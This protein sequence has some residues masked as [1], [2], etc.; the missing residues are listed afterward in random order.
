M[1]LKVRSVVPVN[2][3][4]QIKAVSGE[5]RG[6]DLLRAD[7]SEEDDV[8]SDGAD[9]DA[10]YTRVIRHDRGLSVLDDGSLHVVT[11]CRLN[12][13]GGGRDHLSY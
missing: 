5:A 12:L 6:S 4:N 7:D 9:E 2:H 3:R 8:C 10:L 1:L 11:T 13:R